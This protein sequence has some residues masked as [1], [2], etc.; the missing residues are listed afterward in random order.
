M[1]LVIFSHGRTNNFFCNCRVSEGKSYLI[2]NF[3]NGPIQLFHCIPI[4]RASGGSEVM[5][6]R[7][8]EK[9]LQTQ[10]HYS[11]YLP[12]TLPSHIIHHIVSHHIISHLNTYSTEALQHISAFSSLITI[13]TSICFN[14]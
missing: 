8:R 7:R 13:H 4:G 1:K 12:F 6:N 14:F 11:R 3:A 10:R 5:N 9:R 2:K